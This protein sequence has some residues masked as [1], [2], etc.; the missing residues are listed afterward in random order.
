MAPSRSRQVRARGI[1]LGIPVDNHRSV[2]E[3]GHRGCTS[4]KTFEERHGRVPAPW[5]ARTGPWGRRVCRP[6]E[7]RT[8]SPWGRPCYDHRSALVP[9]RGEVP[10]RKAYLAYRSLLGLDLGR[11]V[12]DTAVVV[13]AA[14]IVARDA[15]FECW[16]D[17]TRSKSRILALAHPARV[18]ARRQL[19]VLELHLL[20][21][22]NGIRLLYNSRGKRGERQVSDLFQAEP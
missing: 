6:R 8:G 12:V 4:A 13:V 2:A 18:P 20:L 17:L 10:Y 21:A 5:E 22:W 7:D 11:R 1:P 14:D 9:C 15:S 19:S 3:E 16:S